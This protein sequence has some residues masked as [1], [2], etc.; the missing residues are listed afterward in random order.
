MSTN[1]ERLKNDLEDLKVRGDML[2]TVMQYEVW[3][4]ETKKLYS[5]N[6][7]SEE[8]ESLLKRLPSFGAAYQAWYSE[9]LALIRQLLPDRVENFK[10]YYEVPKGRMIAQYGNY[11]IQDYVQGLAVR[12]YGEVKVD[13]SAAVPQFRQQ[14]AILEAAKRRFESSLFELRQLVQAELF[15]TELDAARELLKHKFFRAA[16]AIAGVVLRKHLRQICDDHQIKVSKKHPTIGDLN[17]LLKTASII[18]VSE[19]RKISFLAD[20]RNLSDH[21]KGKEPTEEQ[22]SDLIEGTA[23]TLK[24]LS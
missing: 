21:D 17:E 3:P 24:N 15:D 1:L 14:L 20:L 4:E 22:V 11:V 6:R 19:W 8:T 12:S 2:L 13:A 16:G 7:T 18:G 9:A 5:K 10:A 23:K